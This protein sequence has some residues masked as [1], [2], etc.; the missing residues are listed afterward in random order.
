VS[1]IIQA[2]AE[3][4][5]LI[6]R[7]NALQAEA[8]TANTAEEAARKAG[9]ADKVVSQ[10]SALQLAITKLQA[11]DKITTTRQTVA[12]KKKVATA[13]DVKQKIPFEK[14]AL[15]DRLSRLEEAQRRTRTQIEQLTRAK[16]QL[17]HLKQKAEKSVAHVTQERRAN[18]EKLQQEL[19]RLINKK[20]AEHQLLRREM[21]AI[22]QQ[23]KKDSELLKVQRDAARAMMERQKQAEEEQSLASIR[24]GGNKGLFVGV[25]IG[26]IFSLILG[27]VLI[28]LFIAK[29]PV[30]KPVHHTY[31]PPKEQPPTPVV[32]V[33]KPKTV[34]TSNIKALGMFR[35]KL[36]KGQGPLMVKLSGG[37]FMMGNSNF[38]YTEERPQHKVILQS[39]SISRYE[40]TFDEYDLFADATNN[41]PPKDMGWGRGK[42]PV[43]NVNWNE[44]TKYTEWLTKQT[45]RKYRLPSEREWE[46]A[47]AAGTNTAYWW[48]YE[49]GK[50]NAICGMCGSRW[51]G[52][53]TAPVGSFPRN[54]LGLYDTIG[55]VMEWTISCYR[56]S[57]DGAP[58]RGQR[59]E[60]GNCSKYVARSSSFRTYEN[61]LR[62]TKRNPFSPGTRIDTLGFRVV[63]VE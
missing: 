32:V 34:Y 21:D 61:G 35:D 47:A 20:E 9:E 62:T 3:A 55:N 60:G 19:A 36:R 38:T 5:K 28:S 11:K 51:D 57:Y 6:K 33:Q 52:R 12:G 29:K 7:Y 2:K 41:S 45:G 18:E 16:A 58:E 31:K 48:G 13:T 27:G 23:A 17:A 46:Y 54:P 53:K 37:T 4:Q 49:I 39:F 59:W 14:T 30:T 44:A 10:I 8:K 26:I 40:I 43:I 42:R 24:R 22:R 56:P 1:S 15:S 50:N 63:R 25:A